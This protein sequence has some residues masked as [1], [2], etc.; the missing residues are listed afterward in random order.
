MTLRMVYGISFFLGAMLIGWALKRWR[1]LDDARAERLV[2]FVISG[3]APWVLCFTLWQVDF[4]AG[5]L[6]LLP[7]LGL[8]GSV[9]TLLP[10]FLYARWAMLNR[11]Q[12]GSFLTCACFSNVGY[13]G[14]F[15][16]FALFGEQAYGLC[17]LYFTF[18]SP[19]FYTLG[20]WLA[21][22]YGMRP[23]PSTEAAE[24]GRGSP[25][26]RQRGG[27]RP[28]FMDGIRL[29]PFIG[30]TVG[31]LLNVLRVPRPGPIGALTHV[32]I[33][34][35]TFLY[36]VAVGSQLSFESPVRL[37]RPSLAMCL[38]KFAWCPALAVLLVTAAGLTGL[39]RF[40]VLLEASTPVAVSPLIFPLLFGLDRR[41]S[42]ALWLSTT[43]VAVPYFFL[44][45]PLL[46]RL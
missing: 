4:S 36:L 38:I 40:I 23:R 37:W 29:Y 2:R 12:T 5:R 16:A 18:F 15:T 22:R 43:I 9:S 34:L 13:M 44:I 8:A 26:A 46:Q 1:L 6:W 24:S 19:A 45:I 28:A 3:L 31:L 35:D 14:A 17:V 27:T 21:H 25:A 39:P 7:L 42:N 41:M 32:L 20:F 30:L 33:P 10:A 11:P